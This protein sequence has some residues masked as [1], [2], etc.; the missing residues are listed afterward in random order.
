[1][2]LAIPVKNSEDGTQPKDPR[3][4]LSYYTGNS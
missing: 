2:I 1:M 4:C 3:D